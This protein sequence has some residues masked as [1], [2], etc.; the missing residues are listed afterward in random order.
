MAE[1]RGRAEPELL[2]R[3]NAS[4]DAVEIRLESVDLNESQVPQRQES[5][6]V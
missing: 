2:A 3:E 5:G 4:E 6:K 1:P